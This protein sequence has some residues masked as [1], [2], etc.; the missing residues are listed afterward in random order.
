MLPLPDISELFDVDDFAQ[1]VTWVK[2]GQVY[3]ADGILQTPQ[4]L[5]RL[6][7]FT[8][9]EA[10]AVLC[11]ETSKA[12]GLGRGDVVTIAEANYRITNTINN[13]RG[14]IRF[15]LTLDI[16]NEEGEVFEWT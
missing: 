11:M 15:G 9:E 14:V 1:P 7:F 5:V 16:Q 4:M 6:G 10:D 2:D 13:G 12:G 3:G 8:I